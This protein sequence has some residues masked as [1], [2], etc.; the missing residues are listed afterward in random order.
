MRVLLLVAN[1]AS[2]TGLV[3]SFQEAFLQLHLDGNVFVIN[4]DE[5]YFE[6]RERLKKYIITHKID[7]L[8]CINDFCQE[9]VYLIDQELTG[10]TQCYIWFVDSMHSMKTPD[11]NLSQYKKISSFEPLSLIHI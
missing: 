2:V 7:A 4:E 10:L 9:G 1:R 8:L 3:P 6:Q 11:P 5:R